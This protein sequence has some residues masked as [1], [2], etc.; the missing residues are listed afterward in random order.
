MARAR[1]NALLTAGWLSSIRD[2]AA[3]ML[4]SSAIAAKVIRR[5]KSTWRNFSRRMATITIM[6]ES[7]ALVL[8]LTGCKSTSH[9]EKEHAAM[10]VQVSQK[11]QIQKSA[12]NS[13][14]PPDLG[15]LFD[16]H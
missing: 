9:D 4:F 7:H 8:H 12:L 13:N 16:G 11:E 10:A 5:F 1:C 15:S 3:V 6:H 2:A 14:E